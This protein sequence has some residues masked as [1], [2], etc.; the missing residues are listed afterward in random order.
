MKIR[1]YQIVNVMDAMS[2]NDGYLD[3]NC[4]AF[5][6]V[7]YGP[8]DDA[9]TVA[10]TSTEEDESERTTERFRVTVERIEA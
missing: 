8:G 4:D 6:S 3:D 9:M 1:K 7:K 10:L 5:V 2:S